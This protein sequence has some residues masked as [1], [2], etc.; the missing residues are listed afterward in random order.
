M[1][2]LLLA[3]A[4]FAA[5]APTAHAQRSAALCQSLA[6]AQ[7][8]DYTLPDPAVDGVPCT[9]LEGRI[10]AQS[11]LHGIEED[12][13]IGVG[14]S[15]E[16]L[17]HDALSNLATTRVV[18]VPAPGAG[19]YLFIDWVAVIR[20]HAVGV[21]YSGNTVSLAFGVAPE[22][23]GTLA[24]G[25]PTVHVLASGFDAGVF[26]G[27]EAFIRRLRPSRVGIGVSSTA[28]TPIVAGVFGDDAEWS[29]MTAGLPSEM[30]LRIV[31]RY[32]VIDTSDSF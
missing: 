25:V 29:A 32:R 14:S 26:D 24:G 20:T 7:E 30:T 21:T 18:L 9:N 31:T 5:A 27:D 1:R 15:D 23:G 16:T 17:D 8:L 19:K 2:T 22:T 6:A 12:A 3:V 11:E 28:D 13:I 4:I 10:Y